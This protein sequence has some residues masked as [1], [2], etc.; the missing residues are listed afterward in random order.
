MVKLRAK[1]NKGSYKNTSA[2]L[3]AVYRNNKQF[4][5]SKINVSNPKA[6]KKKVF[7][8]LVQEYMDEG[9][10][11]TKAVNTLSKTT[12]FTEEYERFRENVYKGISND[13]LAFKQFRKLVGWKQKIDINKFDYDA[14]E[15]IY[16]YDNRITI[17]FKNSPFEI[18]IG[19]L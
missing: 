13:K 11:P 1:K 14:N 19:V 18:I 4:I 2:W 6:S 8:Q 5:D 9:Y 17:S 12:I 7:K 10:S 3:D 15:K 16:I